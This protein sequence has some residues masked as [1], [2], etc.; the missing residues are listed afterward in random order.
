MT[1]ARKPSLVR[2]APLTSAPGAKFAEGVTFSHP[3]NPKSEVHMRSLGDAVGLERL[4]I[5]LT[6]VAPGKESFCYHMHHTEEEFVYILS[7]RGIAE[8]GDEEHE[9]GP[10]DFMGFPT[11]SVGHHLR[12]PFTEDLVYLSGGERRISEIADFPRLDK[13]MVRVGMNLSIYGISDAGAMPPFPRI[14]ENK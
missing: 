1:D 2:N 14:G 7:G 10:G 6:R 12:N 4:G 11:P 8:I 9:V 3:L 5:N 13:R